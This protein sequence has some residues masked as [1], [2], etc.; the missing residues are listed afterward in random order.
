MA[1]VACPD[2]NSNSH[3]YNLNSPEISNRGENRPS[4][5]RSRPVSVV[6]VGK[7]AHRQRSHNKYAGD[8]IHGD[9][10][11]DNDNDN[12]NDNL[13][14][15][16]DEKEN[17]NRTVRND[18]PWLLAALSPS[19]SQ[20]D[21]VTATREIRHLARTADDAFWQANCAQVRRSSSYLLTMSFHCIIQLTSPHTKGSFSACFFFNLYEYLFSS[22][23]RY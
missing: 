4:S 14:H 13:K 18:V 7:D 12:G 21:K 22:G 15:Y 19:S 5:S 20:S 1:V 9:D 16:E 8:D 2:S 23:D 6:S 10:N 3:N 17:N 11:N